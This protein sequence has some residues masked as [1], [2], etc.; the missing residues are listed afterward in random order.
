MLNSFAAKDYIPQQR[1]ICAIK[2]ALKMCSKIYRN[3]WQRTNHVRA[4]KY[5]CKCSVRPTKY[6]FLLAWCCSLSEIRHIF[7]AVPSIMTVCYDR[8]QSIEVNTILLQCLRERN[9]SFIKFFLRSP[10]PHCQVFCNTEGSGL[11]CVAL[12]HSCEC[13]NNHSVL[14]MLVSTD[15]NRF[16]KLTKPEAAQ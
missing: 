6:V 2:Y 10:Y 16:K 11:K 13:A 9:S 12:F 4:P 5:G 1:D 7:P 14:Y 3:S 15:G 8:L